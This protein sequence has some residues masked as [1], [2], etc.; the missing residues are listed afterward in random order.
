MLHEQPLIAPTFYYYNHLT[1]NM[2]DIMEQFHIG[3]TILAAPVLLP[4]ETHVT[5]TFLCT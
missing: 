1:V 4:S 5:Y 3:E 2:S